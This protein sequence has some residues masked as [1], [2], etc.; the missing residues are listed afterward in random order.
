[1]DAPAS[2][3]LLSQGILKRLSTIH[4]SLPDELKDEMVEV[5]KEFIELIHKRDEE[6]EDSDNFIFWAQKENSEIVNYH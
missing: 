1:L 4:L 5:L 3:F 2:V 6:M